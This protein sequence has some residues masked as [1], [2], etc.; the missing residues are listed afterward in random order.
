MLPRSAVCLIYYIYSAL[1]TV[2]GIMNDFYC[3][4]SEEIHYIDKCK[5]YLNTKL[6]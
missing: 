1:V 5:I 4:L 2:E 6:R 3:E